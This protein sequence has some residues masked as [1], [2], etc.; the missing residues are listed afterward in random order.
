MSKLRSGAA[1]QLSQSSTGLH[2]LNFLHQLPW[3]LAG[4]KGINA[5]AF[6]L[7]EEFC[8]T[9]APQQVTWMQAVF[10]KTNLKRKKKIVN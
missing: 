7:K 6:C 4:E 8:N 9:F 1:E 10:Q 3:K 2:R 5:D